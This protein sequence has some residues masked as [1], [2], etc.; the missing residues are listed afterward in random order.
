MAIILDT[1]VLVAIERAGNDGAPGLPPLAE[2]ALSSISVME[3]RLG[4]LFADTQSR[5]DARESF[6][7]RMTHRLQA[8][9][10]GHREASVAADVMAALRRAGTPIGERDLMIAATAIANGHS[11]LTLN[12]SEFRRVPG[13]LLWSPDSP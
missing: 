6:I 11:V 12:V 4:A 8:V 13:L 3:L 7:Q 2:C 1:S 9:P 5:R 10:F